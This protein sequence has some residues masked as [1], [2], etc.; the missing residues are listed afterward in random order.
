LS[1]AQATEG[2][3]P[4]GPLVDTNNGT[5]T[6]NPITAMWTTAAW[7]IVMGL[8]AVASYWLIGIP[9]VVPLAAISSTATGNWSAGG[10]WV[11]GVPP[12]A[13]DD[14]TI[15][16]THIV[17][18]DADPTVDNVTVDSGGTVTCGAN[19]TVAEAT[20]VTGALTCSTY[21]CQ[22]GAVNW[23]AGYGL[24]VNAGGVF[25]GGSGTHA[26]SSVYMVSGSTTFTSSVCTITSKNG[27]NGITMV[28]GVVPGFNHGSG[29]I[30]FTE[31][32]AC[33]LYGQSGVSMTFYNIIL[34]N[35]SLVL[36]QYSV[37]H[38]IVPTIANDFT[39]TL[40]SF[41]TDDIALT[42]TGQTNITGTL[43]CN[44]STI[45]LGS[46]VTGTVRLTV[47]GAGTFTG[48]N[49]THN[50]GSIGTAAGSQFTATSGTMYLNGQDNANSRSASFAGTFAHSNGTI[51]FNITATAYLSTLNG[52]NLTFYNIEVD[53]GGWSLLLLEVAAGVTYTINGTLT[54]T[55][56]T[57]TTQTGAF[58]DVDL[59]VTGAT[60]LTGTLTCNSSAVDMNG[61]LTCNVG[62]VLSAPDASGSISVSGDI[63]WQG[64]YTHNDGTFT[65]DGGATSWLH[66]STTV[67]MVFY[68]LDC[69]KGGANAFH[70]Y[71]SMTVENQFRVTGNAQFSLNGAGG[72]VTFTMGTATNAGTMDIAAAAGFHFRYTD[73]RLLTVTGAS[74]DFPCV[75]T[76]T[77]WNWDAQS[78][79]PSG[80]VLQD[81]IYQI[82]MTSGG[83][84]VGIAATRCAFTSTMVISAGDRFSGTKIG[85]DRAG[86]TV[87][88]SLSIVQHHDKYWRFG[89]GN[90]R[91]LI[92]GDFTMTGTTAFTSDNFE[93]LP[94]A[95]FTI[96]V[97]VTLT[98]TD[99]LADGQPV[100]DNTDPFVD[101]NNGTFVV[102]ASWADEGFWSSIALWII[103]GLVA[104][105]SY[106]YV[107]FP[108]ILPLVAID[109]NGGG[110]GNWSAGPS[111]NGGAAPGAGDT[112]TVLTADTITCDADPT[113]DNLAI[114]GGGI[115]TCTA[116]LSVSGWTNIAGT[117]NCAT[118]T[119]QLGAAPAAVYG[120]WIN[121]GTFNGGSGTHTIS[122]MSFQAG[123]VTLTS[124]T[125]TISQRNTA[126]NIGISWGGAA[127][128]DGNGTIIFTYAG[129]VL[130]RSGGNVARTVYNLTVNNASTVLY[131]RNGLGF[132]L[133]VDNDLTV[134]LGEFSTVE[135]TSGTSRDLI[136]NDACDVTGTLTGNAS[137]ITAGWM[138]INAGGTYDATSATTVLTDDSPGNS[139]NLWVEAGGTFTHNNGTVET[140]NGW[141]ARF[142]DENGTLTLYN[143]HKSSTQYQTM[144][145]NLTIAGDLDIDSGWLVMRSLG[146]SY[147]LTVTGACNVGDGIPAINQAYLQADGGA[148]DLNGALTINTDGNVTA[149]D[150]SGTFTFA[151]HIN[152][153]GTFTHN[154][155]T[156]TSDFGAHA[157]IYQ[158]ITFYNL[159]INK[160]ASWVL[161][162]PLNGGAGTTITVTVENTLTVTGGVCRVDP[163]NATATA[164]L[165]V[166]TATSS[167]RIINNASFDLGVNNVVG[168]G[169]AEVQSASI[170]FPVICT[171]NDW[172]WDTGRTS[173]GTVTP[174]VQDL[175]YDIAMTTGGAGVTVW[176]TRCIFTGPVTISA[177]DM[178]WGYWVGMERSTI[179]CNG[180]LLI[181]YHHDRYVLATNRVLTGGD[182]V[183]IGDVNLIEYN[184]EKL[185]GST[186]TIDPGVTLILRDCMESGRPIFDN[187]D[188][189]VDT[190]NG[191]FTVNVSW[192]DERFTS[193]V[194]T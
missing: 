51:V 46:G 151:S 117:L 181:V 118:Y 75:C 171:G 45:N 152:N 2:V 100:L 78:P 147:D 176:P 128:D 38:Y 146:N 102:N 57:L 16:N 60:S 125:T 168:A 49:G 5:I 182:Y 124:G 15:L 29:T 69:S 110:G 77:D 144:Y 116:N 185:P 48:G 167:G 10:T 145:S 189:Y 188:P 27:G 183:Q 95:T 158:D 173:G 121:G 161:T 71:D 56:G 39:I 143:Y 163:R 64:T 135:E 165:V 172:G 137:S 61:D 166:G 97:G 140:Q 99:C 91:I 25:T 174:A 155:G 3:D 83:G 67:T 126:N 19:L 179:T 193:H 12:G 103:I 80:V 191:T 53:N 107:G 34:N 148:W 192:D 136:V 59:T 4:T 98:M 154:G 115:V 94:G 76:G 153:L 84:G 73:R 119:C 133:T 111:W 138:L 112:A 156:A 1:S 109:S 52:N 85:V 96:D 81:L 178:I 70:C 6:V 26:M 40:G 30:T 24:Q 164:V 159:T 11:G 9:V 23:E 28:A 58:D 141:G 65:I 120:V 18:V 33:S 92:G 13:G 31:G 90:N 88:G 177:N 37:G 87:N 127:F 35:A 50:I 149:P 139:Y 194:G 132:T 66:W 123:T 162:V 44:A 150:S 93:K 106:W 184:L 105:V 113:V 157:N 36:S 22:F 190:N 108:V 54:V 129:E 134:T 186:Y 89:S 42:V 32:T 175:Y 72:A 55:A 130:L 131:Y 187:S 74:S 41:S 20:S 14:A 7:W 86:M 101:V 62:G 170:S 142:A 160:T 47:N 180:V 104:V 169:T 122:S 21:T 79:G 68:N 43:I 63:I 17:T 82:A 114:D 8:V